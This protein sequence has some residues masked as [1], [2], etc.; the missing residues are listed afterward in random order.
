MKILVC[1]DSFKGTMTAPEAAAIIGGALRERW[2][3]AEIVPLPVGD[4]GEGT[5]EAIRPALGHVDIIRCDTVDALRRP[6]KA[7]Y[8]IA[9]GNT[10]YIESAAASGLTLIEPNERDIMKADTYGTGLL[11]ANAYRRG[12]RRFVIAMGGTATCDGGFGAYSLL[13]DIDMSDAS[14]SL[15]CDVDN[16]LCGPH[17]AAAVFGPQKGASPRQVALLDAKLG[18]LASEYAAF[19]NKDIRDMRYAGA[20]GGLAGM[21]MAVYGAKPLD[22]IKKVLEILEFRRHLADADLVVTGEGKAD[23]T[24]LRGKAAKGILDVSKENGVPTVIIGGKTADE[25]ALLKAGFQAV[26]QA[27]PDDPDPAVT[28]EKY[29]RECALHIAEILSPGPKKPKNLN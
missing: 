24:T 19:R 5:V 1:P 16:P 10:A 17:G 29:L 11:I 25:D 14:W 8:A 3:E 15:L 18:A 4:G 2:P 12:I 26:F 22:G 28:P 20:A 13:R 27:T 21:L 6:V 9:N 23:L 7:T